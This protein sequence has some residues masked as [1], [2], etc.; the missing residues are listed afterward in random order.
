[1]ILRS[2]IYVVS[3]CVC[4]SYINSAY[5]QVYLKIIHKCC[6]CNLDI[7]YPHE[8]NVRQTPHEGNVRL[9]PHDGKAHSD[10]RNQGDP[11]DGN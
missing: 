7:K 4:D 8:G 10:S 6:I 2:N 3:Q 9:N 1:M 5:A 11:H